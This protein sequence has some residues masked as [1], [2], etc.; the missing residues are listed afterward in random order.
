[1]K[2]FILLSLYGYS[3]CMQVCAP[4][5]CLLDT[6]ELGLCMVVSHHMG[7]ENWYQIPHKSNSLSNL[8]HF[9]TYISNTFLTA[10]STINKNNNCI[11]PLLMDQIFKTFIYCVW[12]EHSLNFVC[13]LMSN[14]HSCSKLLLLMHLQWHYK[15]Y[16]SYIIIQMSI[17]DK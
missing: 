7:T 14:F 2:R 9:K 3:V 6:L 16:C 11:E 15:L 17:L 8:L 5:A 10:F 4:H 13:A 1:M 12:N